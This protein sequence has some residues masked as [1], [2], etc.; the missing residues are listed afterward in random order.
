VI[1]MTG[2]ANPLTSRATPDPP[3][4][5]PVIESGSIRPLIDALERIGL[6]RDRLLSAVAM[7][8]ERIQDPD[9]VMPCTTV[10]AMLAFA[11]SEWPGKN[12]ALRVAEATPIGAYP[13]IDYLIQSS[14][15]LGDGLTRLQQYY[16][17]VAVG[18]ALSIDETE[19][20]KRVRME[21]GGSTF[22]AE[23]SVA[24]PLCHAYRESGGRVRALSASFRHTPD[25][26]AEFA[27]AIG[28]PVRAA[29]EWDGFVLSPEAWAFRMPK[30]D[31]VLL[32]VLER[33]AGDRMAQLPA[34]ED[35][36]GQLR[37]ALRVGLADGEANI[38]AIARRLATTPRTLQRRLDQHGTTFHQVLEEVRREAAELHL[39]GS[40]LSIAEISFVLGYSEPAAFHRA[41]RRWTRTTPQAFRA[42]RR[43]ASPLRT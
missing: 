23:F 1:V 26:V 30:G 36:R 24:L 16:R 39:E 31:P 33:Q 42:A 32:S 41:F 21:G 12:L 6:A 5:P 18:A 15:T 17:L 34:G 8:E 13:L 7:T 2:G 3:P 22:F 27:S 4:S 29:A 20:G 28:C 37:R 38:V 40:S 9:A 11:R 10:G 19:E 14:A 35:L 25:D 43:V